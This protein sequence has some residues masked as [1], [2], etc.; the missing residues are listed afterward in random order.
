MPLTAVFLFAANPPHPAYRMTLWRRLSLAWRMQRNTRRVFTGTSY[1]AHLAMAA[2]LLSVPPE[3][4][5]DVVECGCFLGGS[6]ANL[7][8]VCEIVD[9]RLIVYDS[10]EGLPPPEE[11]DQ[12]ASESTA[13]FL[14]AS[15]EQVRANVEKL[16]HI[17]RCEFRAGW[18]SETLD[19]HTSPIAFCFLDVD[20]QASLWDCVTR[21]WPHL[22]AEG[23]LFIDEYV[24]LDYCALFFSERFWAEQFGQTPPGLIGAGAGVGVGEYYLGPAEEQRMQGPGSVAYTRKNFS[25]HWAYYP[26]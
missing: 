21:L 13:G 24:L 22:V 11:G 26:D 8:L 5:G 1:K 14:A 10:F 4:E 25:G 16:G 15:L 3:I 9:R 12:Y 6:T 23:Y 2:K 7:S 18:F 20:Y 17:E 19:R